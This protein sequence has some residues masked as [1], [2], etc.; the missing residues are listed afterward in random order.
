[1]RTACGPLS[2]YSVENHL[3]LQGELLASERT[4]YSGL[5]SQIIENL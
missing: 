5:A 1:M 4:A 2:E 3:Y